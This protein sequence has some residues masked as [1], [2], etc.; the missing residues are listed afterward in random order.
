MRKILLS[1]LLLFGLY[2]VSYA[3]HGTGIALNSYSYD[4]VNNTTTIS[5]NY[6][7]GVSSNFGATTD[8]SIGFYDASGNALT[9][10]S[11]VSGASPSYT[12]DS[13]NATGCSPGMGDNNIYVQETTVNASSTGTTSG[14]TVSFTNTSTYGSPTGSYGIFDSMGEAY[15]GETASAPC[16]PPTPTGTPP[17]APTPGSVDNDCGA[18]TTGAGETGGNIS[19]NV[20]QICFDLVVVVTGE[21][22]L[23]AAESG[24]EGD[25]ASNCNGTVSPGPIISN[26]DVQESCGNPQGEVC[27]NDTSTNG[28]AVLEI[29]AALPVELGNLYGE[30]LSR[31]NKIYWTTLSEINTSYFL[32]ERSKDGVRFEEIGKELSKSIGGNSVSELNYTFEDDNPLSGTTYYRLRDVDFDGSTGVSSIVSLN[33]KQSVQLNIFPMP[34]TSDINV[35]F[36]SNRNVQLPYQLININGQQV[37]ADELQA[38]KGENRL[39]FAVS[40]L[41]SGVYFFSLYLDGEYLSRKIIISERE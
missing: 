3:C 13:Y 30:A 34:V 21:V 33:R 24:F 40:D 26:N 27:D 2:S 20:E 36:N 11:I 32:I 16:T 23:I 18:C 5:V 8:Y 19:T 29:S 10:N 14:N 31:V 15:L 28:T 35:V 37:L 17:F 41:P 7:L 4:G 1:T 38:N 12:Y 6:C 22:G 25:G 39:H 9:V